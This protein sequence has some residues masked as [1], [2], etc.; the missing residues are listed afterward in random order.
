MA[1]TNDDK[2]SSAWYKV[3]TWDGSPL[4]WRSFRREMNW[5]VSSLDLS[6]TAKY[7]LAARWLLRQTGIVRQRGEEFNPEDLSY[8]PAEY[9]T[10]PDTGEEFLIQEADYLFG[11]NKLLDALEGINGQTVLDKRGELRTQFYLE[12]KRK[13]GERLSEFC[14]RFRCLVADL[15]SEGVTL[16]PGELGWFLRDKLGLDPL[17]KQLLDTA[18]QGKEDYQLIEA[19][20]LRLFKDLHL[21]DPLFR[22]VDRDRPKLSIR[23]LFQ[24]QSVSP[25]SSG[26]STM[27]SVSGGSSRFS[28]SASSSASSRKSTGSNFTRKVYLTE[29]PEGEE[30]EHAEEVLATEVEGHD[31][32]STGGGIGLEEMIHQEAEV[33][34]AELQEAEDM[35]VD[36][37][38]LEGLEANLE[39]AAE[40]LV[41][42]KE[43]RSRLQE[44]RKDRG[45]GKSSGKGGRGGPAAKKASGNHLCFD[46]NQSGHWAGDPECTK[47]GQ[48]LGRRSANPK[49]KP[50]KQVRVTE[51][52]VADHDPSP[53]VL[54]TGDLKSNNP[55]VHE[56]SMVVHTSGISLDQA[57]AESI[58]RNSHSTLIAGS[59]ELSEDKLLVGALDSACNRTC[60]GPRWLEGYLDQLRNH[61]PD[62][63]NSLVISCDERENFRFGNGGVV[64]SSKRWRLPC[65][66]GGQVILIWISLVP[67]SSLGCL[68]GRDFLDAV[69]AVLDFAQRSLNCTFLQT[70]SLRLDQ[71]AAG[72]FMLNLLPQTWPRL[73]DRR[74]WRRCGLDGIIELQLNQHEW[75]RHRLSDSS[76]VRLIEDVDHDHLL[77]EGSLL[78]GRFPCSRQHDVDLVELNPPLI[79]ARVN[80]QSPE[81]DSLH[82]QHRILGLD[83][84][85]CNGRKCHSEVNSFL[86]T[87][88]TAAPH[89]S[90]PPWLCS[91]S[92]AAI[93]PS[94]SRSSALALA[95][96]AFV[97][98]ATS[99]LAIL[100]ISISI[101]CI[102]GSV[103]VTGTVHDA[104]WCVLQPALCEEPEFE[105]LHGCQFERDV[106]VSRPCWLEDGFSGRWSADWSFG[107]SFSSRTNQSFEGC[108]VS[109]SQGRCI[110]EEVTIGPRHGGSTVGGSQRWSP[111]SSCR[112]GEIP[113][114]LGNQKFLVTKKNWFNQF[115]FWF[116]FGKPI[117]AL[118]LKG[119]VQMS[120]SHA[121]VHALPSFPVFWLDFKL[122]IQTYTYCN[123]EVSHLNFF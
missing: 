102:S 7:N 66:I 85:N 5:W 26:A 60:T 14:T 114:P 104:K 109:R 113:G 111:S 11:L 36:P 119:E 2:G 98:A 12:L 28:S 19:E 92:L 47:P 122:R 80:M 34:A 120:L 103:E 43:A 58:G 99:L 20:A 64:P 53:S 77:T 105:S 38:L 112:F 27:S 52:L 61:A 82:R 48:G 90:L 6:S 68:L 71:M 13:P 56:A 117:L 72:H 107:C 37:T 91:L 101:D 25:P 75:L 93:C 69:G 50:H 106:S 4:S 8:R 78:A 29:V 15:K 55:T 88:W 100:A 44:V 81:L 86:G 1:E 96:I 49:G 54:S 95:W 10:D 39:Q 89:G 110:K 31:D 17:R 73:L 70:G 121:L 94:S 123:S 115:C 74:R 108:G 41:T 84:G 45:F 51:T 9:A 32:S 63:V 79:V 118:I 30:D 42:M 59:K 33:F 46:C 57:L 76:T 3:P 87:C 97:V 21:S 24:S 22:R 18:L 62:W 23:K 65:A 83:L 35:G 16:P 116:F 67:I 40:T